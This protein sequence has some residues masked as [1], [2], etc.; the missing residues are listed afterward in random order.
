MN[1]KREDDLLRIAVRNSN[2][3]N[4]I[5]FANLKAVFDYD[6]FY[7]TKRNQHRI[8][9]G[10][11]GDALKEILSMGY[12]LVNNMDGGDSF[13]DKQWEEPLILR[14]NGKEYKVYIWVDKADEK[15]SIRIDDPPQQIDCSNYIEVEVALPVIGKE[16]ALIYRLE[17]YCEKYTLFRNKIEFHFGWDDGERQR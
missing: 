15:I 11:L 14:F 6:R 4:I 10:A 1:I 17:Q 3:R 12:A 16:S 7:S 8:S 9:R 5:P 13:I 2:D